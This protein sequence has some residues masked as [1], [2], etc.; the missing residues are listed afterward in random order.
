[1]RRFRLPRCPALPPSCQY[2]RA[3]GCPR[4][5]CTLELRGRDDEEDIKN[6]EEVMLD[7]A[8]MDRELNHYIKAFEETIHQIIPAVFAVKREKP[9][10][11][12]DLENMAQ[13]K[14][15]E[16]E[17]MNSDS[18][19]QRNEKYTYFKDQLKEMKKQYHGNDT[20]EQID[21]D[22]AVTR[23]Q[24]NFICPITQVTM[25]RPVRNK[26]CGHIYEEDAILEMIQ[27]QKQKKKKVRCPKMGCSHVD[28]K[29]SDLVRDEILKRLID[30]QKKQ[31]WSTLDT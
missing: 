26:V 22:I 15:L 17:S 9:E 8:R 4:D 5:S 24:M 13:E 7:Y 25:K 11:L 27:T 3:W 23:S 1:M 29:G 18:D 21:E 6:M 31:S 19:L 10:N 2:R 16:M 14:F 12:P 30:S 28:V 20:I